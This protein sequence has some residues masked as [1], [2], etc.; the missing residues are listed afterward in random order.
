MICYE[1]Q[2]ELVALILDCG[3]VTLMEWERTKKK[4]SMI[5]SWVDLHAPNLP[6]PAPGERCQS[7]AVKSSFRKSINVGEL[8]GGRTDQTQATPCLDGCGKRLEQALVSLKTQYL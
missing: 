4:I 8:G 6:E 3:A 2:L 5:E 1:S 7:L